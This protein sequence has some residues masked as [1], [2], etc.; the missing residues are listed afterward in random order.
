MEDAEARIVELELRSMQQEAFLQELS[1]VLAEQQRA[2]DRLLAE[3]DLLRS[4]VQEPG[5][6]DASR[7]DR[8]PHY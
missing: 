3:V 8:P 7:N 6:V 5:V 2:V 4:K 1:S